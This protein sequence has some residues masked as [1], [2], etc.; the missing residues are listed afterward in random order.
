MAPLV[1]WETLDFGSGHDLRVMGS[2]PKLGSVLDVESAGD[3]LPL[4]ASPPP[5][6]KKLKKTGH[7]Q[8][9]SKVLKRAFMHKGHI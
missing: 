6:F 5:S 4:S 1:K 7:L 3:S 9:C 2:N 8:A